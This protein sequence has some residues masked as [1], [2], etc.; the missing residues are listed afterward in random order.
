MS[1]TCDRSVVFLGYCISPTNKADS[2]DITDILLKVALNII[3]LTLI[4]IYIPEIKF[5]IY[6]TN[7]NPY[8]STEDVIV[9]L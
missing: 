4:L 3:T 5:V 2:H 7:P 8:L 1:V 6:N 9:N